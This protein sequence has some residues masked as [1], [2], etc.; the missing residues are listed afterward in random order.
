MAAKLD[1]QSFPIVAAAFASVARHVNI[2]QKMHFDFQDAVALAGLATAAL[3]IE[4]ETARLIA[5]GARFR[6]FGEPFANRGKKI[7]VCGRVGTRRAA[8]GRLVDVDD[9]VEKLDP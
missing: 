2:R 7:R 8:D 5:A 4:A 3:Y 9:F 6:Q 1:F